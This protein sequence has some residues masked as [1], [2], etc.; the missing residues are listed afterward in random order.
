MQAENIPSIALALQGG[1]SHGAFTWGVLDRLLEEVAENR[2]AIAAISGTSAG[3]INAALTASGLAEGGA[4]RA[5]ERLSAFWHELSRQG[6][7]LGNWLFYGEPGPFGGFNL[8]W[9]PVA[10]ALEAAGL[11]ASPYTDPFYADPLAPLLARALPP[12][13]LAALNGADAPRLFV[14]ATDVATNERMIFSQP[15]VSLD[16]LRAS[17]CLPTTFRAVPI[18]GTPYWDGGYLGNPALSPLLDHAQD[19]LLVLVNPFRRTGMPPRAAPDILGRLNEITFNASVVLEMNAIEAVNRLLAE[20]DAG[21]VRYA[22]RYRPIHLHAIRDDAFMAT[23]GV[24]SK[25]STAWP[26]LARLRDAGHRSAAAWLATHRGALGQRSSFNAR[27][28]MTRPVLK[29]GHV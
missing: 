12:P 21:G 27:E 20:L 1:G 19:L 2:L 24:A 29:G 18:D 26:L 22:G 25:N 15:H 4:S 5:R 6:T 3:A 9:S 13:A 23:L 16:A 11:V 7:M 8:D 28:E 17:A 10:V 14:T